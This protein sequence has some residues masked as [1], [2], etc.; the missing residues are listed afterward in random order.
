MA[1]RKDYFR[2][3]LDLCDELDFIK[4]RLHRRAARS[5]TRVSQAL[6]NE[7]RGKL[8]ELSSQL[9]KAFIHG[10]L[11]DIRVKYSLSR[12]ELLVIALLLSQRVRTGN[13]GVAGREIL[14][15][16]FDSGFDIISGMGI[17][18]ADGNLR[19]SGI[20][21]APEPYREDVLEATFRLSDDMF[22]AIVY[23]IAGQTGIAV[24]RPPLKP[25]GSAREHL[26][27][28]GR[29]VAIYR[30]RAAALFPLEAEDFFT[31]AGDVTLDE[32][33]YRIES[34][35]GDI[36]GR[37]LL[38]PGYEKY[39]IVRMERKYALGREEVVI[40]VCLLF[41]E[42]I[43][44]L[45]Y[46]VV[47]DLLKLVSRDEEDLIGRR[48]LLDPA[49]LLVKSGIVILDEEYSVHRKNCTCDAYLADSVVEELI[50]PKT[51]V[52]GI[53]PDLQID[54]HEFLKDASGEND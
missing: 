53:T 40:V 12:E 8:K 36:E 1:T 19:G 35:W 41:A 28:M 44:P 9:D 32:M 22:Y 25:F 24:P 51:E 13:S 48:R 3:V 34:G 21:V 52:G 17:L 4:K 6:V 33:D 7:K 10:A 20:V 45:P 30:K 11:G 5:I 54:L 15:T 42:L 2:K 14:S 39:P 38:T 49:S 26:I 43:A 37:L 50:G 47:S 23:E 46:L 31:S 18:S 29:L 16:I 27:E